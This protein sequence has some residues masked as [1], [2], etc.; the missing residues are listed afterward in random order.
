MKVSRYNLYFPLKDKYVIYNTLT[1][2]MMVADKE[3]KESLTT[4]TLESIKEDIKKALIQHGIIVADDTDETAMLRFLGQVAKYSADYIS[5]LLLPT[6]S[7]NL[8]CHYCPNPAQS[9][10][11]DEKTTQNVIHFLTAL[12]QSQNLG[13]LLKLYGGEPLLNA[14]CC[15]SLCTALSSVCQTRQV[16]FL[17]AAMTNGTL[18]TREAVTPLLDYVG[19]I[20]VTFDGSQQYH[21]TVRHYRNGKGTYEDIM[22]GLSLA[23]D[24]TMRISVRVNITPENLNSVE[25]LLYDL[26]KR[27]FDEYKG[28]DIYF[29]PVIPLD[30]CKYYEDDASS[31][32]VKEKTY[33]LVPALRKIV[34]K[35]KWKG[36]TRD[37]ISDL[38]SVSKPEQCQYAKA[39][40]YVIGARGNFYTCPA[41]VGNEDYCI[42]TVY[43]GAAAFYPLYYDIHTR[44]VMHHECAACAYLP[45]CGGGCPARAYIQKKNVDTYHCGS[46]KELTESRMLLY[47]QYKR[48]DLFSKPVN[49]G[50]DMDTNTHDL[51]SLI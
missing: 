11:M 42:G 40:H 25:D 19:A 1:D 28:F 22:A 20:H 6:Y 39:Y 16:P 45:V 50:A 38:R 31:L 44:D 49:S 14:D 12:V 3:L 23:R 10:F 51:N 32:K 26:K 24:K 15:L 21:D 9:V 46:T 30:E 35:V 7:C 36:K 18:I 34:K 47:L 13:I 2:T 8:S 48:P 33:A 29:G 37:I 41:F 4:A 43:E 5:V 27:K 17:A